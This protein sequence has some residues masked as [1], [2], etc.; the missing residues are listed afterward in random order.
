MFYLRDLLMMS[1]ERM[2]EST[3]GYIYYISRSTAG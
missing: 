2:T 1:V 3:E